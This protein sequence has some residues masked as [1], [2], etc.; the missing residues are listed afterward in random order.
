MLKKS[1]L[2]SRREK[3]VHCRFSNFGGLTL[4]Q[5]F[6][7]TLIKRSTA[8]HSHFIMVLVFNYFFLKISEGLYDIL[9]GN[10][11]ALNDHMGYWLFAV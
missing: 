10:S 2:L 5:N 3:K 4:V 7:H 1:I 8:V 9:M 11:A 6:V